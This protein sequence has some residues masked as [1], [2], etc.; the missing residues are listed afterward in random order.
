MDLPKLPRNET[1]WERMYD[2]NG[3]LKYLITSD[4]RREVYYLY[5]VDTDES[6]RKIGKGKNP[7]DLYKKYSFIKL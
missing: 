7:P 4:Y 1:L 5:H 3:N 2:H 6:V